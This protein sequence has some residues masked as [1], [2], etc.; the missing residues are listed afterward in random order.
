VVR[1]RLRRRL[2][3]VFRK[4]EPKLGGGVDMVFVPTPSSRALS[5]VEWEQIFRQLFRRA[6][7]INQNVLPP[8]GM[9]IDEK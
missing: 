3:E 1:N 5:V 4:I 8:E 6:G 9:Q 7:L 2:Q